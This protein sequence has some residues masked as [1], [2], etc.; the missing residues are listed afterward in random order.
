MTYFTWRVSGEDGAHAYTTACI[1]IIR[2]KVGSRSVPIHVIGGI[3]D[4]STA[5]ETRGFV[6]AIR[7]QG[8][9]GASYYAYHGTVKRGLWPQLRRVPANPV[10]RP[11]L[12]V[13][14]GYPNALGNIPGGDGTHPHDVVFQTGP[15]AGPRTLTYQVFDA[16]QGE[17]TARVNWHPVAV[18]TAGATGTW[19]GART[20]RLP[21]RFLYRTGKNY[22]SF[23]AT[24]G[25][26]WGVR[27]V[28]VARR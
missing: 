25:G 5:A 16:Q 18:V 27:T 14:I 26:T 28:R 12:P 19:S 22:I 20:L 11:A 4:D 7:E 3:S 13:R 24:G 15:A 1:Q 10:E 21:G 8:V 23:T 9:V 6:H 2:H 17:V